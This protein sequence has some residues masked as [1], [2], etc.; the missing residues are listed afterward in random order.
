MCVIKDTGLLWI[1]PSPRYNW[2]HPNILLEIAD[3]V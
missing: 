2:L 1:T 3:T